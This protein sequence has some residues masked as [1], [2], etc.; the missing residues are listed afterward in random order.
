[1]LQWNLIARTATVSGMMMEHVGWEGD[2]LL[3][4]T[5]KHKGDQEGVRC[6]ARHLFANPLNPFICP[7]LALAIVTFTRVL[8]HA[9]QTEQ[10]SSS[11]LPNYRVFDGAHS[12]QRFSEALG[13]AITSLPVSDQPRLGGDK[14]Q[15]GTHSVRKGLPLTALA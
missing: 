13:R 4:S 9:P 1:V 15:L 2:S 11:A 7:V 8:K 14:K 12:E 6:F 3:I 5:P 10:A